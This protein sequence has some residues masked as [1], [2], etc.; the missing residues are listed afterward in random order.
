M[1][2]TVVTLPS[3]FSELN[4]VVVRPT[5]NVNYTFFI[6]KNDLTAT[7]KFY[8]NGYSY[9]NGNNMVSLCVNLTNLH[10]G[11]LYLNGNLVTSTTT[12]AIYYK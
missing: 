7:D 8:Y 6:I 12:V 10:L 1:G 5:E 11:S 4:I 2:G 3:N 9:G